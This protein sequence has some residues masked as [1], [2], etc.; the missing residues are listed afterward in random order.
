MQLKGLGDVLHFPILTACQELLNI[1]LL[2]DLKVRSLKNM[3][4]HVGPMG[5]YK[6]K[7]KLWEY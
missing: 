1:I 2:K 3:E 4:G 6:L 7:H 5:F